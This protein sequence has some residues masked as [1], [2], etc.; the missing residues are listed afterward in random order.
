MLFSVFVTLYF[1]QITKHGHITAFFGLLMLLFF[2][3]STVSAQVFNDYDLENDLTVFRPSNGYWYSYSTESKGFKSIQ[4]GLRTDIPV[5]AD[6]DGDG[7]TDSAVWRPENGF[8]YILGT[9]NLQL[10]SVQWGT[11]SQTAFGGVRDV[12]FAGD[13]DGD[14]Q[15][16]ISVWRPENGFWYVLKS[17]A[18]FSPLFAVSFQWGQF[19]DVP[20]PA[21]Y[22]GDQIID[23][24]VFRPG[25]KRWYILE[26][27][28]GKFINFAFGEAGNDILIP[29]D[30]TGDG[31]AD[32]A[33]FRNGIW[34]IRRSEDTIIDSY[35]FGYSTDKPA[36]SDYDGDGKIDIAVYRNGIWFIRESSTSNL[37]VLNFG[38][39]TDIPLSSGIIRESMVAVP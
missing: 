32:A 11:T 5:A 37:R 27:K 6:Y 19:G 2:T 7:L 29:A 8:W 36:P 18:G 22:D 34:Y 10:F 14:G 35:F 38:E 17:S 24:A 28:T 23:Y 30:Y 21:D 15:S 13:F 9:R 25:E 26:S 3:T 4:W 16:D 1:M 20:V 12:P 33:V 39:A 31:K